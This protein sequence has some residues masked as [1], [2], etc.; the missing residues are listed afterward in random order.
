MPQASFA[1]S[2]GFEAPVVRAPWTHHQVAS[3]NAYQ[4][5]GVFHP[6]TCGN[7][8]CPGTED[9]D[10]PGHAALIAHEDG[11]QCPACDYRQDWAHAFIASG[12]WRG[13]TGITVRVDGGEPVQAQIGFIPDSVLRAALGPGPEPSSGPPYIHVLKHPETD[14]EIAAQPYLPTYTI[15]TGTETE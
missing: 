6:F 8:D 9:D 12:D 14:E 4:A 3:L 10:E 11:W 1:M 2:D 13:W 15:T 7:D 5:S